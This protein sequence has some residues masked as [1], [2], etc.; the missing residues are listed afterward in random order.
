MMGCDKCDDLEARVVRLEERVF[1]VERV[2]AA[3]NELR[4]HPADCLCDHHWQSRVE[5]K[6]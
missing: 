3:A 2:E 1:A 4:S 5:G 6:P